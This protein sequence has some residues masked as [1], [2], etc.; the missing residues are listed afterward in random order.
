MNQS[1]FLYENGQHAEKCLSFEINDGHTRFCF[2]YFPLEQQHLPTTIQY[3][4]FDWSVGDSAEVFQHKLFFIS[5]VGAN[6]F[7]A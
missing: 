3:G 2:R 5:Y 1:I 6:I 7:V 4:S